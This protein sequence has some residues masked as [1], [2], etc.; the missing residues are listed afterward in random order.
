MILVRSINHRYAGKVKLSLYLYLRLFALIIFICLLLISCQQQKFPD[1]KTVALVKSKAITLQE[2]RRFY[3]LDPNFGI[4][5][6]GTGAVMD[7]L[8][9]MI[10]YKRAYLLGQRQGD[11]LFDGKC[12]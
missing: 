6:A 9:K 3:E 8:H 4:D 5:S 10:D 12:I 11:L 7:E 1:G 2:F